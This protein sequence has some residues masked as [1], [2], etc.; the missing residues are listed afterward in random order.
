MIPLVLTATQISQIRVIVFNT[1]SINTI[2]LKPKISPEAV[3]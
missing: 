3:A 1:S 2:H